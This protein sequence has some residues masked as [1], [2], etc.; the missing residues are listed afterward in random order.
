[1]EQTLD[2]SLLPESHLSCRTLRD[3]IPTLVQ[4]EA[5]ARK[6]EMPAP[7]PAEEAILA[8]VAA[9]AGSASPL[10]R[11]LVVTAHPDDETLAMGARLERLAESRVLTITD[12]APA[13]GADALHHGFS[14]LE[15]YRLARRQELEAALAHA[16]LS[17]EILAPFAG[18][19]PVADQ[20][21]ALHIEEL[22]R[23]IAAAI[24]AF[25]P[26]AVLT[27][28]YEGGHPDHDACSFAVHT[29]LQL[30]RIPGKAL[31]SLPILSE[32]PFYHAGSNGMMQTGEFLPLSN[33]PATITCKLSAAEQASKRERLAC[34]ASQAETLSQFST[35]R[36]SYRI[37]P[38]YN[39]GEP[40]HAGQLFY[41]HFPWGM[42][43]ERFRK[44]AADAWVALL[45]AP[46]PDIAQR[47]DV[48]Q[49]TSALGEN[50]TVLV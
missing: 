8:S 27:H 4:V 16:G 42:T 36:E 50:A 23:S 12:G 35:A 19:K 34:F 1:M 15:A 17:I 39:F 49:R 31:A 30:L 25:A 7:A 2:G 22:T 43:G 18:V 44:L 29:A 48:A 13:N 33:A 5:P 37:A 47:P 14:S 46:R 21:A 3:C 41:E 10:P 45:G 20:T 6:T 28:P 40:P 11:L 9:P 26:T 32:A 38:H 24:C